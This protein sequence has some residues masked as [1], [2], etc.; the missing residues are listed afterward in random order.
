LG[1][2]GQGL[3]DDFAYL[4]DCFH[5]M[6]SQEQEPTIRTALRDALQ[7]LSPIHLPQLGPGSA[8]LP[9]LAN[10]MQPVELAPR[11]VDYVEP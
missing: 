7:Q 5:L 2:Q 8:A 4:L 3:K 1:G 10:Q 9:T 6:L 11:Q